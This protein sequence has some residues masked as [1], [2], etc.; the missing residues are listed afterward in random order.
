MNEPLVAIPPY[1]LHAGRVEGWAGGAYAVPEAYIH[2]VRRAGLEPVV[3]PGGN[4]EA[5]RRLLSSVHS[6]LLIGG[7]DV[8]PRRYGARP[9]P[10]VYGVDPE[11]DELEIELLVSAMASGLPVLAVCRG[12]QVV[13]VALGGSLIQHLADVPGTL[14]HRVEV[15]RSVMHEVKVT[16]GT[17]LAEACAAETLS[18]ASSHH[19]AVDTPGLGL[20]VSARSDDGIVEAIEAELGWLLAVQ[21]H[22]EE[23]AAG[24]P[25]Q[26]SLFDALARQARMRATTA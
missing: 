1:R 2:A 8:D 23:T 21:W 20:V 7:G 11:R 15:G 5:A 3:L 25:A 10:D 16:P 17:R 26:H 13:N 19:Q 9:H 6:L 4:P 18:A 22:P 24:D 14:H 12:A